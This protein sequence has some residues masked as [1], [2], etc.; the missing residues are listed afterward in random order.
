MIK[1]VS[2]PGLVAAAFVL[3]GCEAGLQP[4]RAGGNAIIATVT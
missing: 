4:Y 1:S 2:I 3:S